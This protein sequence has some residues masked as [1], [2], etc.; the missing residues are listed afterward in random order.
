VLALVDTYVQAHELT[1]SEQS[2]AL[3]NDIDQDCNNI[4]RY[5]TGLYKE[6]KEQTAA[7]TYNAQRSMLALKIGRG[8][9]Y[10]FTEG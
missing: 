3:V 2:P 1:F 5:I 7:L 9:F 6:I 10:E 4:T 8:H